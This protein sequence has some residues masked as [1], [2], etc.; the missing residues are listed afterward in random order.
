MNSNKTVQTAY[1]SAW[2]EHSL[3][4]AFSVS[5]RHNVSSGRANVIYFIPRRMYGHT[6]F[7]IYDTYEYCAASLQQILPNS[8]NKD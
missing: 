3:N 2:I 4:K 7:N 6:Y 1:S 5:K 8:G